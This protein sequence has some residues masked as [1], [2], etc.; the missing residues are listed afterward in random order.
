MSI[1]GERERERD[2]M[3]IEGFLPFIGMVIAM[4]VQTGSMV[5]N[6]AAMSKGTNAYIIVVYAN[7]VSALILLPSALI[8]HRSERPPLTFSILCKIFLLALFWMERVYWRSSSSQAKVL[9]TIVSITGAF[10]VT[11]YKGLP[12]IRLSSSLASL[13][14][15]LIL[16]SS[17]SNWILGGFF[18]AADALSTSLW[19]ILQATI[20]KKYPAIVFIVFFQCLF[21]TMQSAAFTLIAVRGASA[22][23]IRLDVGIIAILYTGIVSTVLRY[24]LVTWCVKKAGAFYCSMFKPLG[25]IFGVIMGV[26]FLGDSV[27][28][29]SWCSNNCY[30]ILC[31]DVGKGQ[32]REA[33]RNRITRPKQAPFATKRLTREAVVH[34]CS[35]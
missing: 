14:N 1:E 22:W 12:I 26:I 30:W 19:Y 8:F 24:S 7:A 33:D 23:E 3:S 18:L 2:K 31:H 20:V 15:Q 16:S 6:K 21:A 17:K 4:M 10:V 35:M 28:L 9:G 11:F 25:I 27:Y 29:G 13:L 34:K 32:R 5:V